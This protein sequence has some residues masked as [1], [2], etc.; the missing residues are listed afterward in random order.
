MLF[1]KYR[2]RELRGRALVASP[3]VPDIIGQPCTEMRG[4]RYAS[5]RTARYFVSY[6]GTQRSLT[7]ITAVAVF[8]S[9]NYIDGPFPKGYGK[10]NIDSPRS[11]SAVHGV[12]AGKQS[13][14]DGIKGRLGENNKNWLEELPHIL[15]THRTM[16]KSSNDDTPFSLTYGMEAVIPAEIGMP[17]SRNVASGQGD[18]VYREYDAQPRC[19]GGKLAKW[20]D[21]HDVLVALETG[22]QVTAS[23]GTVLTR[24]WTSL[25][26]RNDI[27]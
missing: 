16:I 12:G 5:A 18:L 23:D 14:G 9:G 22:V 4:R 13:L 20:K 8:T 2:G 25:T 24:T 7:L 21:H 6:K 26:S 10:L 1:E 11:T 27:F 17:R 15:W 3:C 19:E